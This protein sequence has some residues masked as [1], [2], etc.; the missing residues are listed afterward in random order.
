MTEYLESF[1]RL[2]AL[3]IGPLAPGHGPVI[4]SGHGRILELHEYRLRREGEI[5]MGLRSGLKDATEIASLLYSSKAN[6]PATVLQLGIN[7]T[8]CHLEHLERTGVVERL[9]AGWRL[10]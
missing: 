10:R 7:Q 2:L 8:Q 1:R 3:R 5:L 6:L 9:A 4:S